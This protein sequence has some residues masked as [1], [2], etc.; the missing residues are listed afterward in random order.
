MRRWKSRGE[1]NSQSQTFNNSEVQIISHLTCPSIRTKNNLAAQKH[2]HLSICASKHGNA[3]RLAPHQQ[4]KGSGLLTRHCGLRRTRGI[5]WD[6][7]SG[8]TA[9]VSTDARLTGN[10]DER[11]WAAVCETALPSS[12][13]ER[14]VC[15]K[16]YC[17]RSVVR[18]LATVNS[19]TK[20]NTLLARTLTPVL[21]Q[22][23]WR[24]RY[25]P[26][27]CLSHRSLCL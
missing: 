23:L 15:K 5:R 8:D 10:A 19:A 21:S 18:K 27:L 11:S 22:R 25:L 17:L 14:Q 6:P 13:H 24:F 16:N 7:G 12:E 1:V 4:Q 26:S 9:Q 2:W 3:R 20:L